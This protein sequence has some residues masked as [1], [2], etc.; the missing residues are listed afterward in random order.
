MQTADG[1]EQA[2]SQQADTCDERMTEGRRFMRWR[3][4]DSIELPLTGAHAHQRTISKT[5]EKTVRHYTL[6][7]TNAAKT[8]Y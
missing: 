3:T 6:N 5:W 8:L 7:K 1:A 2:S 4:E